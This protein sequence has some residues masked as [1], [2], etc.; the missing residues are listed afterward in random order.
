[1][2]KFRY[3]QISEEGNDPAETGQAFG[4]P[5]QLASLYGG[6]GDGPLDVPSGYNEENPEEPK[7]MPGRPQKYKSVYGTDDSAFGRDRLGVYDLKSN[8]ETKEDST[9]QEFKG[10]ALNLENTMAIFLKNKD[11]FEKMVAGRKTN[12]FDQ[13]G[14]LNEDNIIEGLD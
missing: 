9:K 4:T 14:L 12:L 7:K 13:P 8:A 6:K 10:G 5:H 2:R 3:K 1:M 11:S